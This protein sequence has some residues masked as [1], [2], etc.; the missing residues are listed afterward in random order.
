MEVNI[1]V[2]KISILYGGKLRTTLSGRLGAKKRKTPVSSEEE[3]GRV[4]EPAWAWW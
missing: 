3:A 4:P 2:F 1:H